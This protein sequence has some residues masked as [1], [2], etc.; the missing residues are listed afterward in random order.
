MEPENTVKTPNPDSTG[1]LINVKIIIH[2]IIHI[3]I[4]GTTG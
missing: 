4:I 3:K 1:L 2:N